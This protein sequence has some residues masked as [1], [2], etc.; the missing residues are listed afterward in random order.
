ML[1]RLE[2]ILIQCAIIPS[3]KRGLLDDTDSITI[4][5][6]GSALHTGAS[7]NGKPSCKCRE[8]G[9]YNCKCPRYYSDPTADWGYDSYR[10]RYYFGHTYYRHVVSTNGHDLPMH[11]SISRAS[12]TN[13]TLSPKSLDRLKKALRENG[14]EWKIHNAVYD[15][16]HD[17]TGI[18]EYLMDVKI[19]SIIAL[20]PRSGTHPLLFP[21]CL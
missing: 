14:L 17:A 4:S 6:D 8:E 9:I 12:E 15:C 3:A 11:V 20:N 5:G 19:T 18:Y 13:F 10:E 1:K 16:G 21:T 7:P 2:D